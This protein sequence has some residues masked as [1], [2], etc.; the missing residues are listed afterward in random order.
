[1]KLGT[2]RRH[3]FAVD[4]FFRWSLV[5][6]YALPPGVLRPLLP[7]GLTLDTHG[8]GADECGFLAV[9]LVQTER[10]RPKG[11]P[12]ALGRSFFL[13]GYR[14]FARFPRSGRP[15]LRGLRIL[16]SDTDRWLMAHLGNLFTHYGYR[17]ARV[18]VQRAGDRL[19]ID[20]V[21]RDRDADLHVEADLATAATPPADSP[22]RS[23]ADARRF[24]GPLPHTFDADADPS[25]ML[26][27]QGVRE[28]WDP[29]PVTI[30][31]HTS[32]F[33]AGRQFAGATRRLANAFFVENVPY[34]WRPGRLEDIA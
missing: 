19:T 9:A 12:A 14:I 20:V 5:L 28:S 30:L 3:P 34:A 21:S 16:R 2:L 11:W 1:M 7:R 27:V 15:A 6:T 18:H 29:R 23:L 33:L 22:F 13:S 25:K 24:A 4:A 26:V 17:H 31:A 10:L 8:E 32:S